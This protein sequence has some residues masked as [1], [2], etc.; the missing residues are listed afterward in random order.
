MPID[1]LRLMSWD[2]NL[3]DTINPFHGAFEVMSKKIGS[4]TFKII[5]DTIAGSRIDMK[6]DDALAL[7]ET[8]QGRLLL[9]I[10]ANIHRCTLMIVM[11]QLLAQAQAFLTAQ[12]AK[13]ER[14]R[15][16]RTESSG[17]AE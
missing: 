1:L 15:K 10:M 5:Q 7:V 2:I 3:I 6:V 8:T 11:K 16:A 12:R 14:E 13:W 4:D 9:R 17:E